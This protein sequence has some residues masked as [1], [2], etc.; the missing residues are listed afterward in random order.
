[1]PESGSADEAQIANVGSRKLADSSTIQRDTTPIEAM[2]HQVENYVP[3][4]LPPVYKK[5]K[6]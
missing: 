6:S 4:I 3:P 1:M 5:E 2:S